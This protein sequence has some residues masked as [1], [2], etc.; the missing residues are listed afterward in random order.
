MLA[1]VVATDYRGGTRLDN[2]VIGVFEILRRP[3]MRMPR[4]V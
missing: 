2:I 1:H 3:S 4:R